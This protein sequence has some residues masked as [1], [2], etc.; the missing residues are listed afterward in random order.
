DDLDPRRFGVVNADPG[1]GIRLEPPSFGRNSQNEVKHKGAG[2]DP[3]CH[4]ALV[5]RKLCGTAHARRERLVQGEISPTPKAIVEEISLNRGTN[6]ARAKDVTQFDAAVKP[7]VIF[8]ADVQSGSE[9][10]WVVIPRKVVIRVNTEVA[11]S[12]TVL[13]D[14]RSHVDGT[15]KSDAVQRWWR[16][17]RNLLVALGRAGLKRGG[18]KCRQRERVD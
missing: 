2:I 12:A 1:A 17:R 8:R 7:D 16:R 13:I 11:V 9:K 6:Y 10:L 15:V 5:S 3:S 18:N 4:V 14:I